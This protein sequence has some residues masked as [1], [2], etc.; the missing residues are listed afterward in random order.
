MPGCQPLI[1]LA[2]PSISDRPKVDRIAT[3]ETSAKVLLSFS[4]KHLW[5]PSSFCCHGCINE[6]CKTRYI[7][8]REDRETAHPVCAQTTPDPRQITSVVLGPL[9]TAAY[10]PT[11]E[12]N[13]CRHIRANQRSDSA[14]SVHG[15][16]GLPNAHDKIS[17]IVKSRPSYI[18]Q[19]E[20]Q[21]VKNGAP[22]EIGGVG[23]GSMLPDSTDVRSG[24]LAVCDLG[25]SAPRT[26]KWRLRPPKK[27]HLSPFPTTFLMIFAVFFFEF[28]RQGANWREYGPEKR[29]LT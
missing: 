27:R 13:R 12:S 19:A 4:I 7:V 6:I 20:P 28:A 21:S 24:R 16:R 1:S 14:Q 11:R 5:R 29:W 10:R 22:S 8:Y 3:Q 9:A 15:P 23:G 2:R 18:C 25:P 26:P 17:T